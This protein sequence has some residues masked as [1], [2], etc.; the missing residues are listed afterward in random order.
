MDSS[1]VVTRWQQYVSH[2]LIHAF[3]GPPEPTTQMASQPVQPLLHSLPQSR[4]TLRRAT[5]FV[6]YNY[7]FAWGYLNPYLIHGSMGPPQSTQMAPWS[8]ELFLQGSLVR[9]R[10]TDHATQSITT[11]LIYV[12]STAMWPNNSNKSQELIFQHLCYKNI[13]QHMQYTITQI[14]T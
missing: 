1:V 10:P 3:F 9:D 14:L 2:H 4:Y 6:P 8:V 12:H 13:Q 7:H 5:P 11:G